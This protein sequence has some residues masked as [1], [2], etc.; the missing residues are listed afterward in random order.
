M[1]TPDNLLQVKLVVG[2][3]VTLLVM[4]PL[5]EDVFASACIDFNTWLLARL[6]LDEDQLDRLIDTECWVNVHTDNT[7]Y[8]RLFPL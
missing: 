6:S 2:A 3:K 5:T 1:R 8:N 7:L 4:C